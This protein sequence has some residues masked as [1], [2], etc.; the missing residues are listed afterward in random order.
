[1]SRQA[2]VFHWDENDKVQ[3]FPGRFASETKV[4]LTDTRSE[5]AFGIRETI[6]EIQ[7]AGI[8]ISQTGFDLLLIS[9]AVYGADKRLSRNQISQD[10]W[11]REI[12]IYL[13]V[14]QPKLWSSIA[15]HLQK[16]LGFLTG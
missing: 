5:L 8:K 6:Q 9:S 3:S 1:M 7:N 13:P 11:T 15:G 10:G 16:M 12:D 14:T 4:Q 2:L